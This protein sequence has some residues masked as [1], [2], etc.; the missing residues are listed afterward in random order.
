[1]QLAANRVSL[2][3]LSRSARK[4]AVRPRTGNSS[5]LES[6]GRSL[7]PLEYKKEGLDLSSTYQRIHVPASDVGDSPSLM[8]SVSSL[9]F[10]LDA[11]IDF[12]V[13]PRLVDAIASELPD[14]F[15][16]K[17]KQ[18]CQICDFT[19]ENQADNISKKTQILNDILNVVMDQD[20]VALL[21]QEDY[22]IL[23]KCFR[24]NVIR[25]TPPPLKIWFTPAVMDFELDRI[26]E[27]GWLHLELFYNILFTFI[28]NRKFNPN[29]CE[30]QPIKLIT[31]ILLMFQSPD[32]REREK[33][34]KTFHALYKT[35]SNIRSTARVLVAKIF[36]VLIFSPDARL[37]AQELLTVL[38]P[39]IAGFH[40]PLSE[41]NTQFF[42][43][44]LLPLH[45]CSYF[46]LFHN[47][48]VNAIVTYINKDSRLVI[49]VIKTIQKYWPH[50]AP[51]KQLIFLNELDSMMQFLSIEQFYVVHKEISRII[52]Q[53]METQNFAIIEQTLMLWQNPHFI[54]LIRH[55]ST[56]MYPKIISSIYK[57]AMD[58]WSSEVR[59][60]GLLTM[61]SLKDISPEAFQRASMSFKQH[62]SAKVFDQIQIGSIW[63]QLMS[64]AEMDQNEREKLQE[65][66]RINFIGFGVTTDYLES[67]R[68]S[69][70]SPDPTLIVNNIGINTSPKIRERK[71]G[72]NTP[73]VVHVKPIH[74]KQ[75]C[76][77]YRSPIAN[78]IVNRK[79]LP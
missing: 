53:C 20:K 35:F 56:L 63:H 62:E 37:G 75:R 76:E 64:S 78:A 52:N 49:C 50:T 79:K 47:A 1:M 26:E 61:R 16:T 69:T 31:G 9:I 40:T 19:A 7:P 39:I 6:M 73:E 59:N 3:L 30:D 22:L 74:V 51:T 28:N 32:N 25:T 48:L 34:M 33:V 38:N 60:L 11:D 42:I 23:F 41:S 29:L 13:E 17:C 77:S 4:P 72:N 66:I 57:T 54:K 43:D 44:I 10:D 18:C 67:Q 21:R 12:E 15:Y 65:R 36:E 5:N 24:Y 55:Y 2:G 8:Y 71:Q 58:N 46:H 27:V 14:L 68:L 70:H 45:R